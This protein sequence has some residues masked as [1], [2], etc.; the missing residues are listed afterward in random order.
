VADL[1]GKNIR[2]RATALIEIAHPDFRGEL[3]DAAKKRHYVFPKQ[4]VSRARYPWEEDREVEL[5]GRRVRIRPVRTSDM[6]TLQ[7]M[8]Y[9]LSDESTYQR[10]M[11]FKKSHPNEEMID[12]VNLDYSSNM[13][14]VVCDESGPVTEFVAMARYDV[15]PATG[16]ADIAFVVRDDWQGRGVG[17]EL[18]RRMSEIGKARGLKGFTANVLTTNGR[19]LGVFNKSG[20]RVSTSMESGVYNVVAFFPGQEP[21]E[22]SWTNLPPPMSRRSPVEP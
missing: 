13:A 17:T 8:F 15:D 20:L 6:E 2:E 18:M 19:M 12:L 5:C 22:P 4:Q 1:W 10:F 9:R 14:L 21:V 16:L 7:D 11:Q 3:L